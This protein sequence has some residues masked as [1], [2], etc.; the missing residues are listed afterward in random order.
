MVLFH[1]KIYRGKHLYIYKYMF[2]CYLC[3]FSEDIV[4][5]P[6]FGDMLGGNKVNISGPCV[7]SDFIISAYLVETNT[8]V[9]CKAINQQTATCDFPPIFRTGE[10]TLQY[11][12][13]EMGWNYS[14][15]YNVYSQ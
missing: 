2:M 5:S 1:A 8:S 10:M 7:S 11:N 4:L 12:P 15:L 13:Y 3:L 6:S 14:T 9:T